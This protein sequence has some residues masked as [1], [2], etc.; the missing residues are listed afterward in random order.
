MRSVRLREPV[1]I[2]PQFV[3]T[4]MSAI[5]ASPVS[6]RSGLGQHGGVGIILGEADGIQ[7]LGQRADLVHLDENRVRGAGPMP[8]WRNLTLVTNRSSPTSWVVTGP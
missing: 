3:A 2:C 5:V 4:A 1:L 8:F 6:R 7:R